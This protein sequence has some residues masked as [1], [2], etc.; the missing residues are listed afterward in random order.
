MT[1]NYVSI[2]C[3]LVLLAAQGAALAQQGDARRGA[4][5]FEACRA[6]HAADG[7][8][9]EVGP[10]L[11]GVFGRKAGERGDFRYSPALKR[12]NITWSP[13]TM[14]DFLAD[15]QKAVPANRMPYDG[16]PDARDRA[17]LIAFMLQAFK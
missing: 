2:A 9:N 3:A 7:A 11:R 14:N 16:V 8:V 10:G 1:R 5:V 4:K 13:Q 15:P 17:D 12:S 6:C